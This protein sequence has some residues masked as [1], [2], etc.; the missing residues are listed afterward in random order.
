LIV[1][2]ETSDDAGVYKIG[3]DIALVQTLDFL[4]P[5]T[6]SPYEFGQIAAANSL[7]DVYAMG[8]TP[9]TAMN[10]VCF[11]CDELEE[12]VLG[13]V[14]KGGLDKINESGAV[15]VGGHS[16]DDKEFKY[17]LSVTGTV[18]PEKVWTNNGL[19]SGDALIL[20]KPL[21]TGIIAT[22]IKAKLATDEISNKAAN[23]MSQLNHYAAQIFKEYKVSACT[24]I[25][26]FGLAGHLFEMAKASRKK[27]ILFSDKVPV[28]EGVEEF[29]MMGMIPAG[30][31]KNRAFCQTALAIAS[32]VERVRQDILFDPQ[33][34]GGLVVSI[35]KVEA[36]ICLEKLNNISVDAEIIGEVD[37]DNS[38]GILEII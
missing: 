32:G 30:A 14:L 21:G 28:I 12:D 22:A 15:L 11:S 17:G 23:V 16:V 5:V 37:S 34:S 8:G 20:T 19:C 6:N 2:I 10:I 4:T 38:Q 25:T 31:H 24:D 13:D 1:G 36:E 26:G 29:A 18:H 9:L 35:N 27:I 33:T 3:P 7:S